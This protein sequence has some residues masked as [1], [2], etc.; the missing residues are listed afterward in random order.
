[1]AEQP[2]PLEPTA[3]VPDGE[4]D[5]LYHGALDDFTELRNALARELRDDG[6][7]EAADWAKGL[8]K[9]SRA[10]WLVNQ[11][12]V[13]KPAEVKRLLEVA[14]ELR[15]L[16][17]A[18]LEGSADRERLREATE[19]EREATDALLETAQ[20]IGREHKVGAQILDRVDE[21]LRAA[22]ADPEVARAIG[23]GRLTREQRAAGFGAGVVAVPERPRPGRK[24]S[25]AQQDRE[26]RE[27]AE[28]EKLR[29]AAERK[30]AAVEK[31]LERQRAAVARAREALEA[32]EEKLERAERERSE[33]ERELESR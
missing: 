28:A 17:Q 29:R 23:L 33:A 20:A 4:L 9:P 25:K 8:T 16:Q 10:A 5:R 21:T 13:R 24:K 19:R 22:A 12:S 6:E 11:L 1:M 30:L 7:R 32:T 26:R 2:N 15:E 18:L 3:G 27:R 14:E 31:K